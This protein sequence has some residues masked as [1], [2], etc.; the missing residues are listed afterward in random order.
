MKVKIHEETLMKMN[1]QMFATFNI[2]D[3]VQAPNVATYWAE[4]V[5]A[6]Q[7]YLGEE[8]FPADKQLGMKLA[9]LKGKTGSP[10]ALRPSAFDADVI[11]RGREG[12]Q[13]LIE[14]M[15]FFKE[16]Y[17]IDEELRQELNMVNQTNNAAYRDVL[18]NRVFDDIA[19]LLRGAAVRREIMRMQ[20]LTTGSIKIDENGQSYDIDYEIPDEHKGNA[21]VAWSDSEKSDPVEDIEKAIAVM[22]EDGVSPARAIMNSKTFRSLRQNASIKATILGNNANAQAAKLSKQSLL[23]YIS[24]E[25][26]LEIV[27]YDKVYTTESGTHKFVPDE[28][29]VLLPAQTL[30][31]TWFGTTPEESDL[32]AGTSSTVSIVDT[33]VAITTMKK[34]DPVNVETKVS[35]ISLPSFEQASSVFILNTNIAGNDIKKNARTK[36]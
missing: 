2:F 22:Q 9:W 18:L 7:P 12:F 16:S 31:K 24:E 20:M 30:G 11:P 1:L 19:D 14:K 21:A 27:I 28:T 36:G 8:L 32:M 13:E 35:M 34:S 25:L 26:N 33:G 4:K 15:I 6:A 29:F 3:L 10:V 17:Y 5:N 23:D